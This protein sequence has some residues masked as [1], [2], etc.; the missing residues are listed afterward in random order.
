M[1][2]WK[3][4][5]TAPQDGT[6][7][8]LWSSSM[9][10]CCDAYYSPGENPLW[11]CSAHGIVRDVTHWREPDKGPGQEEGEVRWMVEHTNGNLGSWAWKDQDVAIRD[12][13]QNF[14]GARVVRVR[15]VREEE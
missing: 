10:R 7:V 9:G 3:P 2:T 12:A 14:Q 5:S 4:I 13:E 8:A 6:E 15:I 1:S 11:L